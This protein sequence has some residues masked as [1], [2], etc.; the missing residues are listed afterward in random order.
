MLSKYETNNDRPN[1]ILT[2]ST[3]TARD[4]VNARLPQP[5]TVKR[6]LRR[7]R[8]QYRPTDPSSLQ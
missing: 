2:F 1:Q 5:D 3:A 4:D 8:E 6:V 7:A